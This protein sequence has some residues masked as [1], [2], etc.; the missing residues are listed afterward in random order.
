MRQ[1]RSKSSSEPSN[2]RVSSSSLQNNSA[3]DTSFSSANSSVNNS[4]NMSNPGGNT[5]ANLV[6]IKII[7]DK[8]EIK[9]NLLVNTTTTFSDLYLKI[10]SKIASSDEIHDDIMVNKLKYKDEDGDFVV[11]DSNDDW[12][13]AMD[14]LED[15]ND[16]VLTIWV[17]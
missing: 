5:S 13:L 4:A 6:T 10:S 12:L 3:Q 14:M 16:K 1:S 2:S 15:T 17:S 9:S 11:M 8:V 7:Y